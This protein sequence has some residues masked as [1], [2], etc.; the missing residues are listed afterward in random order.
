MNTSTVSRAP[1]KKLA[2][3]ILFEFASKFAKDSE[4]AGQGTQYPTFR[5]VARRFR[6]NFSQIE[7]ACEDYQGKGYMKPAVGF[8]NYSGH[9]SFETQGDWLVEAYI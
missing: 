6:V 7:E 8:R 9:G 3:E 1:K 2:S 5:Q 4:N